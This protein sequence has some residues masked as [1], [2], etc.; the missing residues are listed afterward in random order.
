MFVYVEMGHNA[1]LSFFVFKPSHHVVEVELFSA[2]LTALA[3]LLGAALVPLYIMAHKHVDCG[4]LWL[5]STIAYTNDESIEW[6]VAVVACLF[7]A[8]AVVAIVA[9]RAHAE[10][11]TATLATEAPTYSRGQMFKMWF[12]WA[13]VVVLASA[14]QALYIISTTLAPDENVV[15]LGK[16]SRHGASV[17]IAP[18]FPCRISA[19]TAY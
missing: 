14:P 19:D 7:P 8:C 5:Y 1:M 12:L 9:L 13:G 10:K 2:K 17:S 15:Q 16:V 6:A 3:S 11:H 18:R 4:K